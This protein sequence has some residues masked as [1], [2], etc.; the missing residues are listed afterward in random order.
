MKIVAIVPDDKQPAVTL[1]GILPGRR[2]LEVRL[3]AVGHAPADRVVL[4]KLEA[5]AGPADAFA[6]AGTGRVQRFTRTV[7]LPGLKGRKLPGYRV[8]VVDQDDHEL[9]RLVWP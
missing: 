1:E 5:V 9:G 3:K 4:V 2:P 7:T 6:P 8:V